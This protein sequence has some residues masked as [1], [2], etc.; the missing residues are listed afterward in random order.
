L[1]GSTVESWGEK[2]VALRAALKAVL[3]EHLKVGCSVVE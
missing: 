2:L 3:L 1:V